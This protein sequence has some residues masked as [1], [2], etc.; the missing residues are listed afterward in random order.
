M[1]ESKLFQKIHSQQRVSPVFLFPFFFFKLF[2]FSFFPFYSNFFLKTIRLAGVAAKLLGVSSVRL[3][4]D[5]FYICNG[6]NTDKNDED[7]WI[8][9]SIITPFPKF[10]KVIRAWIPLAEMTN[11]NSSVTCINGTHKLEQGHWRSGKT[12]QNLQI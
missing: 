2:Q 12:F 4:H 6:L 5:T 9:E 10:A 1:G 7:H 11:E 3:Y 8:R